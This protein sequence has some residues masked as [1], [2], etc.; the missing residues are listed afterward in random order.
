VTESTVGEVT[1]VEALSRALG[2]GFVASA[3]HSSPI[4]FGA[5]DGERPNSEAAVEEIAGL[6][7]RGLSSAKPVAWA[8]AYYLRGLIDYVH[9]RPR[10]LACFAGIDHF[11]LDPRGDVYP[12]NVGGTK[13]GNVRDGSYAEIAARSSA[14]VRA[15]VAECREQCWMACTVAPP[16]RRHPLRPLMWIAR[17]KLF[18]ADW[19]GPGVRAGRGGGR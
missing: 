19:P 15:A 2:V 9:R 17:A 1:K 6:M 7:R 13:M 3:A 16:M 5:H 18:G 4:Y 14:A 8:K 11:F 12:C 10:R